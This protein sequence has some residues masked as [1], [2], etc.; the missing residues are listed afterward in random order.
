[1]TPNSMSGLVMMA[2]QSKAPMASRYGMSTLIG[3]PIFDSRFG[4]V[5]ESAGVTFS[6][7]NLVKSSFVYDCW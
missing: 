5:G 1:M 7:P 3:V 2:S 6:H 4:F